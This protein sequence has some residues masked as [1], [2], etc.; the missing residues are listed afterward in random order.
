MSDFDYIQKNTPPELPE[1]FKTALLPENIKKNRYSDVLA[2]DDTRV[3]LNNNGYINA[4]Y[5]FQ[6]RMIASQAPTIETIPDFLQMIIEQQVPIVVML[7]KCK[8]KTRT[9]ATPYWGYKSEG[10][11]KVFGNYTVNT[12]DTLYDDVEEDKFMEDIQIRYLQIIYEDGVYSFIQI[13]YMGW[14]DFGVPLNPKDA[15]DL[16]YI[17]YIIGTTSKFS[18]RNLVCVHCSAGVG[19][20][21]V[22]CLLSRI[23]E[24]VTYEILEKTE[25]YSKQRS[26]SS[27]SK[28]REVEDRIEEILLSHP[29]ISY[30]DC[31]VILPELVLSI[32]NERSKMVQTKEQYDFICETVNCFYEDALD[33]INQYYEVID[34]L[35]PLLQEKHSEIVQD[36]IK[37]NEF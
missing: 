30:E 19:R 14:P 32:R 27:S 16:V 37:R 29:V 5:I 17:Q 6:G 26:T 22:Y 1:K 36:F 18:N 9:K 15:L 24:M 35:T 25:T 20:T 3:K 11:K 7:T 12:I 28:V 13:H 4:N 2:N 34:A 33:S 10:G 31:E 8:E 21:G 23:V